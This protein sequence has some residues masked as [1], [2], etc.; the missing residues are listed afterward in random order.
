[1]KELKQINMKSKYCWTKRQNNENVKE[2]F[3]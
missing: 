3:G 2:I 1:M